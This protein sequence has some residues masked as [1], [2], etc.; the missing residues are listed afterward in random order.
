[1]TAPA[2]D[3]GTGG[4][5]HNL[6]RAARH[7]L[8]SGVFRTSLYQL[9]LRGSGTKKLRY[10]PADPWGGDPAQ[11]DRL[12]Q[13]RY[14]FAGQEYLLPREAPWYLASASA[15]WTAEA[16]SFNYLRHFAAQGGEAA[17]RHA[18][19][20]VAT[21]IDWNQDIAGTAWRPDVVGER[22]VH[23]LGAASFLLRDADETF[24]ASFERSLAQQAKHLS[25]AVAFADPGAPRLEALIGL[26]IATLG[27]SGGEG[28]WPRLL[29]ELEAELDWQV[30]P[31]GGHVSRNPAEL[32]RLLRSLITLRSACLG[33][34]L[35]PPLA[36]LS[37][38]D[39]MAPMLRFFRHGDGGLALFHGGGEDDWAEIELSLLKADAPGRPLAS[40]PYS[41]FER[42]AAGRG[43]VIA[44]A[45]VPPPSFARPHASL[46]ALEYSYGRD[47]L[48]VNCG[49]IASGDA[50]WRRAL[51]ASAAHST[52]VVGD[53]NSAA[54]SARRVRLPDP[55]RERTVTDGQ[56]W[57]TLCHEGYGARFG[58]RH[59]RRI[60][61]MPAGDDLR[62]EDTLEPIPERPVQG[63]AFSLRFHLHPEI[64]ASLQQD[65]RAV[66]LKAAKGQCWR[67]VCSG[68]EMGLDASLY[69][70]ASQRRRAQ[71]I[72]V[73]GLVDAR[74]G[75]A[76]SWSL[77]R[78]KSASS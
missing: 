2:A 50:A 45:G 25:H 46:L 44:D 60:C 48:I 39:R 76:A 5:V 37:A 30:L 51:A 77:T 55:T 29:A 12:F 59:R 13:G 18:R 24:V 36:V 15:A 71:Q 63:L 26:A 21:W 65:K 20:L 66:L 23:W 42:L 47:R 70:G 56:Q 53:R 17:R 43:L 4:A 6:A 64:Q 74:Q 9:W 52:L 10:L 22:L 35:E 16:N 41:G 8:A 34:G 14:R 78:I 38:I 68:G 40:A 49:D 19:A 57:L 69:F 62:G 1:M 61:L 58:L 32:H 7:K 73:G 75:A 33:A 11:A 31:D 54:L 28:R 67:F 3:I 72:V 27:L